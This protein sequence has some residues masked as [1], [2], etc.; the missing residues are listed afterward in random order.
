MQQYGRGIR[1]SF[2][3][4]F[5]NYTLILIGTNVL[6]YFFIYMSRETMYYLALNPVLFLQKHFYWTPLTY[7]FVHGGMNHI[8]FNML[9]LF[10]FGPQ[11]EERMGSTEFLLYYFLTGILSGLF[12][13][14]VYLLTGAFTVFLMGASGAIFA[15]LLAFAV[16]FPHSKVY[17]F[18]ILPMRTPVMVTLYAGIEIFSMVSGFQ[19]GVA[20]MTHLA[21]LLFGFLYFIIRLG[22]NPITV[23]RDSRNNPW[24]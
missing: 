18:G 9:G 16:Y 21:G 13:L 5:S 20:H 2:P 23:F 8:L 10:F 15:V 12:S 17:I 7:M 4:H 11:L 1:K 14:V 22:T 3:Y 24:K 19:G 6:V